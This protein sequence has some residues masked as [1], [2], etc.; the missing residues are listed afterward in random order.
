LEQASVLENQKYQTS[1]YMK[2]RADKP[3]S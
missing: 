3:S 1:E 2:H